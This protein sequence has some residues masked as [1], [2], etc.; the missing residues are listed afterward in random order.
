MSASKVPDLSKLS[1]FEL[2][3]RVVAARLA[4]SVQSWAVLANE[5]KQAQG[6]VDAFE[7]I[8][9]SV[10]S[11]AQLEVMKIA[12]DA[13]PPGKRSVDSVELLYGRLCEI[14]AWSTRSLS[15]RRHLAAK[16]AR[17]TK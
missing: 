12:I 6:A 1:G 7:S 8:L 15:E 4:Q 9:D 16:A 11:E 3:K 10:E 5:G 2:E 13:L 14:F 17:E